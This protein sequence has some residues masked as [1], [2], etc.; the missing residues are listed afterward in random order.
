MPS[1]LGIRR[2]GG[3]C[4]AVIAVLSLSLA[5][6]A[7][8]AQS[9]HPGDSTGH[10]AVSVPGRFSVDEPSAMNVPDQ[11]TNSASHVP[12]SPFNGHQL[13]FGTG[14]AQ[15]PWNQYAQLYNAYVTLG[16]GSAAFGVGPL[17]GEFEG[18]MNGSD[19][20]SW[21]DYYNDSLM[22]SPFTPAMTMNPYLAN[23]AYFG[24]EGLFG[25]GPPWWDWSP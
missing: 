16:L 14:A 19:L 4:L 12:N 3:F 21:Y 18:T 25:A 5:A 13:F 22:S 1:A 6:V 9:R 23:C 20:M 17:P 15:C 2:A 24:S 7:G 8:A 11:S 10:R